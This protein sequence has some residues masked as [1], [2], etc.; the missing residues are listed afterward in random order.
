LDLGY[1]KLGIL[2]KKKKKIGNSTNL[3][4]LI[5]KNNKLIKI[6][7]DIGNLVLFNN[8]EF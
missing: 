3:T 4:T 5:I 7:R 2:P 6:P 1:N 8:K